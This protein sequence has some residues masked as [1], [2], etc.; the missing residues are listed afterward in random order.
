[1]AGIYRCYLKTES[2]GL[3]ITLM[4]TQ[5]PSENVVETIQIRLKSLSQYSK[6]A[7]I[8]L[9]L[10][11]YD[12]VENFPSE[13]DAADLQ[14]LNQAMGRYPLNDAGGFTIGLTDIMAMVGLEN[15]NCFDG[16]FGLKEPRVFF[17]GEEV[18]TFDESSQILTVETL[19]IDLGHMSELELRFGIYHRTITIT[20]ETRDWVE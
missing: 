5:P 1:V 9:D 4:A 3:E 17:D 15:P 10:K 7:S 13:C 11:N 2:G 6:F 18:G 14:N 19:P 8:K 12:E 20:D 16:I